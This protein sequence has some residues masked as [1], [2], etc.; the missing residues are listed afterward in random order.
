[1]TPAF[2][3][4][5]SPEF[6]RSALDRRLVS[7]VAWTAVARW[8]SQI[9]SWSAMLL[10]ARLLSPADFGLFGMSWFLMG[11][12]GVV[13]EFGI[14]SSVVVMRELSSNQIRQ[15]NTVSVLL[16]IAGSIAA[17]GASGAAAAFFRN[18]AIGPLVSVSGIAFSLS[19]FRVVPQAILARDLRFKLFA[20]IEALVAVLQALASVLLAWAGLGYWALAVSMLFGFAVSS[21]LFCLI[22]P[23]GFARP[24]VRDLR[25][26]LRFSQSL[27]VANSALFLYSNA[28]FL[29]AGRIL[30]ASALG[31]YNMAWNLASVP[32]DRILNLVLRVTPSVL[33]NVQHDFVELRRYLRVLT[34]GMSLIVFPVGFGAA[35]IA[36][37]AVAVF[38][39]KR[40]AGLAMPLRL[41]AISAIFRC[42]FILVNQVQTAI[43]DVR[44]LMWQYLACLAVLPASFWY[45][46]RWGCT[47]I[48]GA[49]LCVYPIV[50]AHAM[51][52]VLHSISMSKREYLES[53]RP[54][55]TASAAMIAAVLA[56]RYLLP[57]FPPPI[58]CIVW[59]VTGA[60]AYSGVL[61]LFFR[62]RVDA[63]LRLARFGKKAAA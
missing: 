49:W 62:H 3:E 55:G 1:M 12:I 24:R 53:M 42:L 36:D 32:V 17:A 37:P 20:G 34:E 57:V 15:A 22:S 45:A 35:L 5:P 6:A 7:G 54:A 50:N 38:F 30:G 26:Q 28:D 31:V 16:G 23:C 40:W 8:G 14:G 21:C 46:S 61:F 43:R 18:P 59:C 63:F 60:A 58:Q 13:S 51:W 48:A 10:L 27:L 56:A 52:R 29:V 33:S 11:F 4:S 9:V 39:D 47:G 44:Y 25:P 41:L 19:A 2:P